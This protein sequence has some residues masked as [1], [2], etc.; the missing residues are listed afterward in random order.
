MT[1][2]I[3]S[4]SFIEM[5]ITIQLCF[6]DSDGWEEYYILMK[7]RNSECLL[8]SSYE[9]IEAEEYFAKMQTFFKG[10]KPTF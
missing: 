8:F 6:C 9:K 2:V 5:N 4:N 1:T 10:N 3:D 7:R